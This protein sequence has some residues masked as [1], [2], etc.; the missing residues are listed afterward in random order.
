ML[1]GKAILKVS[2][3]SSVLIRTVMGPDNIVR[4]SEQ[5]EEMGV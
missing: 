1:D 3:Q 2:M 4:L 5:M